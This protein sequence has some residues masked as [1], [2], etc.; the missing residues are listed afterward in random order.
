MSQ[1][2]SP[3]LNLESK[4]NLVIDLIKRY[5]ELPTEY[6]AKWIEE[7]HTEMAQ[8]LIERLAKKLSEPPD[9]NAA[10]VG[11]VALVFGLVVSPL[12]DDGRLVAP[13]QVLPESMN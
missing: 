1:T 3:S 6:E 12:T 10:K 7:S 5:D 9:S 13:V 2:S 8:M 11:A 4:K